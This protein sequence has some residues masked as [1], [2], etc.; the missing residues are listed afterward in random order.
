LT[1][2]EEATDLSFNKLWQSL[3]RKGFML[4]YLELNKITQEGSKT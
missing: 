3:F 2:G 4:N 1:P